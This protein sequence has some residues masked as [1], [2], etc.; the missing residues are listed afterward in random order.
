M[1]ISMCHCLDC[2]RRTGAVISNQARFRRDQVTFAGKTTPWMRTA[3]SGKALTFH[4]CPTCGSTVY[5]EGEGFPGYVAVAIGSFADPD[6]PAPAI[7][8]WEETPPRGLVAARHAAEAHG[9]TGVKMEPAVFCQVSMWFVSRPA[10][11]KA[12][13][14]S[15]GL[16]KFG[17]SS[18]GISAGTFRFSMI[19]KS[20]TIRHWRRS[21][22]KRKHSRGY[23]DSRQNESFE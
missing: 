23:C 13:S 10:E 8:V 1:R 11:L 6:F 21:S 20:R 4:F 15:P 3:E 18:L 7:A 5:W 12:N 22:S 14:A 16:Q 17:G 9:E 19:P 2:Q